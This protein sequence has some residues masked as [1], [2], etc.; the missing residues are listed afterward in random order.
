MQSAVRGRRGQQRLA[1]LDDGAVVGVDDVGD[2]RLGDLRE[3]LVGVHRVQ[4]VELAEPAHQLDAADPPGVL[5]RPA[6]PHGHPVGVVLEPRPGG[7]RAA[8]DQ[9]DDQRRRHG[10]LDGRAA[11]LAL[12]LPVVA[13]ADREQRALDVDAEEAGGAGPHLRGVHVAAE[14]LGHQRAAH[15]PARRG[16]ADRA[17]HRLDREVDPQV[18]VLR[19]E[20]DR[21][22]R[23]VQLV[24]PGGVRQRVLQR[25]HAV[26]A[27][28]A[29]EERDRRRRAPVPGGLHGH[30]VQRQ[31]VPG[32]GALDVERPGL[33]VDEAQVDLLA[34]Q[35]LDR[36]QRPAERVVGPQ[37]QRRPGRDPAQRGDAAEGERVLLERWERPRRRPWP[38]PRNPQVPAGNDLRS[39]GAPR[40]GV[41]SSTDVDAEQLHRP[42]HLA[43]QDVGG[44][45]HAA[46]PAGHQPVQVGP[47][48]QAGA[49]AEGHRRDD[50]GAVEDAA[51]HV[52][53]G[54]VPD[55]RHDR[56]AAA[57]AASGRGRAGGRRGWTRRRR[58]RRRRRRPARRR[59]PGCP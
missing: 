14:A 33:R 59:R 27:G 56:R 46:L 5:E 39:G 38:H 12:A 25:G 21:V 4:A 26:G 57:P 16:D 35:V 15:L 48:D 34:G 28:Q 10:A 32:L 2:R 30:E 3:Q 19:G 45:L 6:R 42:G 29:A 7:R 58:R 50:V 53:L 36:A 49:G 43:G 37:A 18:A 11:G 9:L 17:E 1:R 31:G 51:V 54:P 22:A 47:A 41:S 20:G 44:P 23:P 52:D 24:D 8:L 40:S 13:V 55:G